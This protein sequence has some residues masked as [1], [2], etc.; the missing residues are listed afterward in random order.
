VKRL[1]SLDGWRAVS[2]L[3]VLGDHSV[4][5]AGFPTSWRPVF[6]WVFYGN[7]GV[8]AFFVISGLLITWLML[9]ECEAKGK[10]SLGKFYLR[11]AL[12]ILPVYIAF[13]AVVAALEAFTDFSQSR[14]QWI[15]NLTF[16]TGLFTWGGEES[17]ITGHLWSLAV[18]EQFYIVWPLLFVALLLA[19]RTR[20]AFVVL[21][22]PCVVAA[23]CRVV[24]HQRISPVEL[25]FLFGRRT[26][27]VNFDALA[28]GCAA[29]ILLFRK[30]PLLERFFKSKPL[31]LS[32]A[33]LACLVVPHAFG[34]MHVLGL[35]IVPFG[36][37][38][39][40]VGIA[41]LMLQS[42]LMPAWG[43]Y[44]LLNFAPVAWVGVLSYS[45]YIW[46][47][48]FCSQPTSFGWPDFWWMS[49]PG[50]LLASFVAACASYYFFEKPLMNLRSKFRA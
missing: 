13:L 5:T 48:L 31:W 40:A 32:L 17:H 41:G 50:W 15:A 39:Q 30:Q 14:G 42:I 36:P 34:K 22:I 27:T 25:A 45:L 20:L 12:R 6:E 28:V 1:P 26:F 10:V 23:V 43:F 46:Q 29:A 49:F 21:T 19:R 35:V 24:S 2:I 7:L 16:T 38:L 3:I 18:E 11:R 9:R 8:R 4:L 47:Q 44:R 37:T 33:A